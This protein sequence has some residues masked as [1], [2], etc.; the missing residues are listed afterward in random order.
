MDIICREVQAVCNELCNVSI[1]MRVH[2]IY[3]PIIMRQETVKLQHEESYE[4]TRRIITAC[5]DEDGD[6]LLIL[7]KNKKEIC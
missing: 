4:K 3:L 7:K 6:S 2:E 5:R 1:E